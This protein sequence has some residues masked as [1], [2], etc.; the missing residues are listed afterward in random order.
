MADCGGVFSPSMLCGAFLRDGRTDRE[1]LGLESGVRVGVVKRSFSGDRPS[2]MKSLLIG[3]VDSRCGFFSGD[4]GVPKLDPPSRKLLRSRTF[5]VWRDCMRL[6]VASLISDRSGDVSARFVGEFVI[7][8][9][10]RAFSV[11][12]ACADCIAL[13]VL[14]RDVTVGEEG[15]IGNGGGARS[16]SE[17]SHLDM[18]SERF[19]LISKKLT[20]GLS[21]CYPRK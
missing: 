11:N 13:E 17:L 15:F 16:G 21:L 20:L 10:S 5:P 1:S 8:P 18:L 2:I 19:F 14:G 12:A 3:G 7:Y 4:L 6:W 9:F